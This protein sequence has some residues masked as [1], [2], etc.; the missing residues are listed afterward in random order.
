MEDSED[1]DEPHFSF[2]SSRFDASRALREPHRVV[3]PVRVK[4]FSHLDRC[5][6]LL[7]PSDEL[8]L[9]P[10]PPLRDDRGEKESSQPHADKASLAP[11]AQPTV[12]AGERL[13][14]S[15][16]LHDM[17]APLTNGR[18]A[19]L[20]VLRAEKAS[21]LVSLRPNQRG[22][23][24]QYCGTLELY[25]RRGNV[26]LIDAVEHPTRRVVPHVLLSGAQIASIERNRSQ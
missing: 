2:F 3:V 7:P 19:L 25:D 21:T 13:S 16:T 22:V 8:H 10:P 6:Y 17:M 24:L 14:I 11:P 12:D 9:V 4:A 23:S 26:V 18:F 1:Y 5:R 20:A 15:N